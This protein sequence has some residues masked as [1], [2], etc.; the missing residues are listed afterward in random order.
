MEAILVFVLALAVLIFMDGV[1]TLL[2]RPMHRR[3]ERLNQR[4][5]GLSEV[6]WA[7]SAFVDFIPRLI[8]P[9]ASRSVPTLVALVLLI[10][11]ITVVP[12]KRR[13]ASAAQQP[14]TATDDAKP[15]QQE[16][17]RIV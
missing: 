16:P 11:A 2:N 4:R 5:V 6:L 8:H 9:Q 15:D 13:R 17:H 10:A 12:H 3:F 7:V 1:A 14:S